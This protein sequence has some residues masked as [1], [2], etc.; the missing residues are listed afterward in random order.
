MPPEKLFGIS[1]YGPSAFKPVLF[2]PLCWMDFPFGTQSQAE[3]S[4]LG[5]VTSNVFLF[6]CLAIETVK[7]LLTHVWYPVR[8]RAETFFQFD[9]STAVFDA[10][11]VLGLPGRRL[12]GPQGVAP[13]P[14][15]GNA[16]VRNRRSA[17]RA[18]NTRQW[19]W[20]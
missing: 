18:R 8:P 4:H 16:K 9:P 17:Q 19:T 7:L 20:Q 14:P 5:R 12:V 3:V 10:W 2:D 11:T 1:S 13:A 15:P 6:G